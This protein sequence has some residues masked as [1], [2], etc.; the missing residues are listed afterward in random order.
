MNFEPYHIIII[1]SVNCYCLTRVEDIGAQRLFPTGCDL[2]WLTLVSFL[3]GCEEM[4]SV[5]RIWTVLLY[6]Y[7]F[8]LPNAQLS[9]S[10]TLKT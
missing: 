5:F 6:E 4:A 8:H 2:N 10:G 1:L 3:G 9:D 7:Y